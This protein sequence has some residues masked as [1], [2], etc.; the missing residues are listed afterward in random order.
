MGLSYKALFVGAALC[1][2]MALGIMAVMIAILGEEIWW[3][4]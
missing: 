4:A 2:L 3:V 1:A